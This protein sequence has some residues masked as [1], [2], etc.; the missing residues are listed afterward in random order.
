MAPKRNL[1]RSAA[2]HARKDMAEFVKALPRAAVTLGV[3]HVSSGYFLQDIAASLTLQPRSCAVFQKDYLYLFYGRPCYRKP[4]FEEPADIFTEFPIIFIL[5]PTK[6]PKP[7]RIFPFD[8]G[9]FSSGMY[10]GIHDN[11]VLLEDFELDSSL[12]SARSITA[13]VFGSERGYLLNEP[14]D[15]K[16]ISPHDDNAEARNYLRILE[17]RGR[18][19]NVTGTLVDDRASA[20]EIIYNEEIQIKACTLAIIVPS[21]LATGPRTGQLLMNAGPYNWS[22]G[23]RPIEYFQKFR[24]IAVSLYED[25]GLL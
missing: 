6:I 13:G 4:Q 24:D 7:T 12:D 9:A 21:E 22:K 23:T 17:A 15:I 1:R 8:S 18:I 19:S 11:Y 5:D 20:V 25:M 10:E 2:L 16:S 3:T 14:R